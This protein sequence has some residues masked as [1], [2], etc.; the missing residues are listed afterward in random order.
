MIGLAHSQD[1]KVNVTVPI[2]RLV[3]AIQVSQGE[4][5]L[6]LACCHSTVKQ[7]QILHLL[8]EFCPTEIKEIAL[9]PASETFYTTVTEL[10]GSA[11][12]QALIVKGLES[13]VAID[14]L[15]VSTNIMRDELR[16]RFQ[17]PLVLWVNDEILQK[18]VWLA[19]DLKNW[20]ACTI[21]FD[22]PDEQ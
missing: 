7:T 20:A 1:N 13:V 18:L 19:P 5:L 22:L 9:P 15:L 11:R 4:F 16:K 3:R 21:R 10:L 14:Q 2:Q 6:L 12:P 17:Y 8:K